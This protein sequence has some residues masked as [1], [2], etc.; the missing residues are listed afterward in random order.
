[1]TRASETS[2]AARRRGL[3]LVSRTNRLLA[4]GAVVL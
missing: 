3:G 4:T 1:M 2:P